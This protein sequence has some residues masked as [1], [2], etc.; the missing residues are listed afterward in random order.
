MYH[1]CSVLFKID[2]VLGAVQLQIF[3]E[4]LLVLKVNVMRNETFLY[5]IFLIRC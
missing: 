4:S 1:T 5:G 2:Y 3:K